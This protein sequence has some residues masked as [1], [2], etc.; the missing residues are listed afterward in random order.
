MQMYQAAPDGLATNWHVQH[1]HRVAILH[2][3]M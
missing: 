1:Q 3:D 2:T